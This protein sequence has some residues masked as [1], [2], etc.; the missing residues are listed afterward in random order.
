MDEIDIAAENASPEPPPPAP[1][2]TEGDD[3]SLVGM[4][5]DKGVDAAPAEDTAPETPLA[6]KKGKK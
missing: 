4:F 2:A 5:P 1:P 3:E 6:K